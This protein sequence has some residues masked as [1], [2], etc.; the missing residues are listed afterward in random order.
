MYQVND[1]V[2]YGIQGVC[3]IVEIAEKAFASQK[4][5]YYVLEPI[6]DNNA[7]IFIPVDN[8]E[9]TEKMRRVLSK[10]EIYAVIDGIPEKKENWIENESVRKEQYGKIIAQGDCVELVK[11]IKALCRFQKELQ[12]E[13]KKLHV[14]DE[15]FLKDAE[16]ILYDEFA[17]VLHLDRDNVLPFIENRIRECEEE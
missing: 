14:A 12:E 8:E 5:R 1:S 9:L 7:T 3:K 17:H 6:Y 13:G 15:H 11:L 10:E 16:K 2:L 4:R